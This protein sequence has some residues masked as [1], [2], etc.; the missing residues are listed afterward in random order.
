MERVT[1]LPSGLFFVIQQI[2]EHF[3]TG[4]S[5]PAK[6]KRNYPIRCFQIQLRSKRNREETKDFQHRPH[7]FLQSHGRTTQ[8]G[9]KLLC[10]SWKTVL[11]RTTN[12]IGFFSQ[13]NQC[14]CNQLLYVHITDKRFHV[15]AWIYLSCY[16][17]HR[18]K[19][20]AGY[21]LILLKLIIFFKS[22][23]FKFKVTMVQ[24][25]HQ[26]L[27]QLAHDAM[28]WSEDF[29]EEDRKER[30]FLNLK[31]KSPQSTAKKSHTRQLGSVL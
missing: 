8:R 31:E 24:K 3:D 29:T 2:V 13:S 23:L 16:H 1:H 14:C 12:K 17:I 11:Q 20:R 6:T 22:S 26:C 15:G 9:K 7:R 25:T 28:L 4:L 19:F 21:L 30:L 27:Q 18:N 10:V 5:K